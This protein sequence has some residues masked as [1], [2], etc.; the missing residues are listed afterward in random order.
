M[1][2]S[3]KLTSIALGIAI[4]YQYCSAHQGGMIPDRQVVLCGCV[5]VAISIAND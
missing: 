1:E 4:I 2:A 3:K 5:T